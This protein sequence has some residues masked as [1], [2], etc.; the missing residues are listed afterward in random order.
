MMNMPFKSALRFV[1]S[2]ILV[3]IILLPA[4]AF[5][6]TALVQTRITQKIDESQRTVLHGNVH[7][8]ARPEFDRGAAPADLP[9]DR[10]LLVLKRSPA[11]E[12]AVEKLIAD[13]Q[14]HSS[15]N[16]HKWLTPQEFG[17]QFGA[18]DQDIATISTWLQSHGF[19]VNSVANGRNVIEFSGTAS[20]VVAAFQTPIHTF[21]VNGEQHWANVSDPSIPKALASVV[22]GVVSLHDF[23][24]KPMSHFRHPPVR[25]GGASGAGPKSQV[26]FN[27]SSPCG[28]AFFT[29]VNQLDQCFG[30][31]PTDF[32]TIYN[33]L[34]LWN[35]GI[36]GTGETI[37]IVADSNINVNDVSD[38]RSIFGLPVNPPVITV[39]GSDPG[40]AADEVEAILD[41]EWSGAVAKNATI[42]LVVS[43]GANGVN[44]SATDIVNNNLGT[45]MSISFGLCELGLGTSGNTFFNNT[46][47]QAATQG[48][49]VLVS[50][51]DDG[52]AGCDFFNSNGPT[53]QPAQFGLAVNGIASTPFNVAVGGTEF[54]DLTDPLQFW[55]ATNTSST[56]A[57]A[58]GYITERTYNDT[59]ADP[60]VFGAFGFSGGT[61]AQEACNDQTN[62]QP[63]GYVAVSGGAGGA[64]SCINGDGS[65]LS[66]CSQ[67]Y[68]KPCWQGGAITAGCSQHSGINTPADGVRDLPDISLFAG[69]G[70]ISGSFYV[71]CERDLNKKNSSN[72]AC[73]LNTGAFL[74][75]GGTSIS[76]QVFAGIVALLNQKYEDK[77]GLLN[78][79]LYTL[80]AT[81]GNTCNSA[82]NPLG[83]CMF[84]DIRNGTISMPCSTSP[85]PVNCA[86]DG[87]A[88]NI[89]P[90]YDA[91]AGFDLATGLGS[92]N[93]ANLVNATSTWSPASTIGGNDFAI[94]AGTPT[95]VASP[96]GTATV[97][98]T[99]TAHGAFNGTVT[100]ACSQL[101]SL[102]T[103]SGP[104]VNA[105]GQSTITFQ[106]TAPSSVAPIT[107]V[108][109]PSSRLP[110]LS[111]L[112]ISL[113]LIGMAFWKNNRRWGA[114]LALLA[115]GFVFTSAGCGGGNG[116]GGG[117]GGNP[118]TPVGTT[119]V[120]V[121]ATSGSIQRSV[122]VTLVVN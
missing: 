103:C 50:S 27:T 42:N 35:A 41:V 3:A 48:I 91:A 9:M 82:A 23:A 104:S 46:F 117:G 8:L 10:M 19:V 77:Q 98:I 59:C 12:A 49:T 55:N 14:D 72:T 85:S 122:A 90:G 105:S 45:I 110:L 33:V 38:F 15:S 29:G 34:P 107:R 108:A 112:A 17:R 7:P 52:S 99:V 61:A 119:N 22:E 13:Q 62:V 21:V 64:S 28:L 111:V 101:P 116:G 37:A 121:T 115:I 74:E 5:A 78:P 18:S 92:V 106:T 102:T 2:A 40:K 88:I 54:D 79:A 81:N 114:V 76:T 6:Q 20:Q 26:S 68:A 96:G 56:L 11:Q 39:N 80:A 16:F 31:G 75:A 84:Y 89:L 69:D 73:N 44:L 70:S 95:S 43:K 1:L 30:L 67:G 63:D 24:P 113:A 109:P 60:V 94:S 83:T 93:V 4:G 57:S 65:N 118:G 97:Q 47:S 66:S 53:V 51:G 58:K 25:V 86:A 71:L 87:N 36:D 32:A 100:F 120:V